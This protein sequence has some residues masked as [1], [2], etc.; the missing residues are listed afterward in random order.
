MLA[1]CPTSVRHL[2]IPALFESSVSVLAD[3]P[4]LHLVCLLSYAGGDRHLAISA[5]FFGDHHVVFVVTISR[6]LEVKNDRVHVVIIEL[7]EYAKGRRLNRRDLE[8]VDQ[9]AMK[10]KA[11]EYRLQSMLRHLLTSKLLLPR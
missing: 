2:K 1:S 4:H 6:V 5:V 8:I 3:Q 7:T 11:D 9:V 10:S